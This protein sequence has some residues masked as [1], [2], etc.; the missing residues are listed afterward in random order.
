MRVLSL[1]VIGVLCAGL[2]GSASAESPKQKASFGERLKVR[3]APVRVRVKGKTLSVV[4]LG[5]MNRKPVVKAIA[6][7]LPNGTQV[8][9]EYGFKVM[10]DQTHRSVLTTRVK[11]DGAATYRL[12][13]KGLSS[14]RWSGQEKYQR[15][16]KTKA[17]T[18]AVFS[19]PVTIGALGIVPVALLQ[20]ATLPAAFAIKGTGLFSLFWGAQ[21]MIHN[22]SMVKPNVQNLNQ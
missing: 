20:G 5:I 19:S 11:P 1:V 6:T 14:R 4:N 16:T 10:G 15:M 17:R 21:A 12:E 8:R 2:S 18:R 13:I 7:Q 22:D 3:L 9:K